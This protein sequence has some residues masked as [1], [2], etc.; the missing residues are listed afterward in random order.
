MSAAVTL[1]LSLPAGEAWALAEFVKRAGYSDY[2]PLA[3]DAD[4]ATAM[5]DAAERLRIALAESGYAPR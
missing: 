5:Q 4:E 2:R 1:H 3:V